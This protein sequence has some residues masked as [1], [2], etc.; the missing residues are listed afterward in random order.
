MKAGEQLK[1]AMTNVEAAEEKLMAQQQHLLRL[2][3]TC[4]VKMKN[5]LHAN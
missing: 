3:N 5:W 2:Q 1:F 4:N